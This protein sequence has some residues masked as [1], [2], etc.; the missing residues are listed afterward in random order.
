MKSINKRYEPEFPVSGLR[1]HPRNARQG[2]IGAICQSIDHN[3]FFGACVVQ[4]GTGYILVGNHRYQAA[5]HSGATTVPAIFVDVDDEHAL[6]ILLADNR[7]NDLA[8]YDDSA[9][10]ELLEEVRAD[11]GLDGTGYDDE[12]LRELLDDLANSSL[13][14]EGTAGNCDE[15]ETP[16]LEITPVSAYGDVWTCGEHRVMCG[17]STS[18]WKLSQ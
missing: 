8:S 12:A 11:Y 17:D 1:T 13:L 15:D 5:I 4:E 14:P 16:Q 7:T 10:A 6:K 18:D 2:D 9:L 3:G